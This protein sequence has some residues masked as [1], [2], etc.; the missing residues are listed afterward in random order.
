M[1]S[2]L[3]HV[4]GHF[5]G[6]GGLALY[7]QGWQPDIAPQAGLVIVH[8][9][10][11]H[12]GRYA[13]LVGPLADVGIASYAFDLRGFGRSEGPRGHI[14]S[15][16][17]YRE[18][19]RL[20][21]EMARR[22]LPGTP[23]FLFGYSLG[24]L[25]VLD[26]VIRDSQA[27]QGA[28]LSGVAVDPAGVGNPVQKMLARVL[29][30]IMPAF[31]IDL[32]GDYTA[33]TRDEA[34]IAQLHADPLHHTRVSARWG[35]ESMN[36]REWVCSRAADVNLPV[37]FVHGDDDRVNLLS[38]ARRYLAEVGCADKTL[39][40]YPGSRHETHNDL[41]HAQ[42]AADIRA[43]IL[44]HLPGPATSGKEALAAGVGS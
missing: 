34:V 3:K 41:D 1:E 8:G 2:V 31:T 12:S 37:L 44:A 5:E 20:F 26:Y 18:D 9:M 19:L 32:G 30:R 35:T 38:G 16:R 25:V 33:V 21:L 15:W 39:L 6:I 29:S 17:E 22:N 4:D 7:Y 40:T 13:N 27:V 36:V 11:D 10:G 43:W 23:L 14:N 42:V 28:V 24:T